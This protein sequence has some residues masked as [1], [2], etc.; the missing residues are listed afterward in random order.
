MY[1]QSGQAEVKAE[2]NS[3]RIGEQ[4]NLELNFNYTT[5]DSSKIVWPE[6]DNYLTNSIEIIN[7]SSIDSS[8]IVCD[9]TVCPKFK[10]QNLIITSFEPGNLT[11]PAIKFKIDDKNYYSDPIP[12]L[13]NTVAVDTAKGMYDVY[14]IYEVEYTFAEKATDFSKQY[15]HWFLIVGLLIVIFILYKKYKNRPVEYIAPPEIIIPAHIKALQTLNQLKFDK[16]W[17]DENRKKY[18]SDLT[19][20]VRQYLEDRF[21]IQALEQTTSEIIQDLKQADI[22]ADDKAFL[23]QILQQADFV[24]FA[25]FEPRNEGGL[26]ALDKSFEFVHRTKLEIMESDNVE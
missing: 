17:E 5:H 15:W 14:P 8:N 19:D 23:Q 20:T 24:K 16:A 1:G 25:K 21:E 12:L 6:F 3:I 13:V 18:Y 22:S 11:I 4:I 7:K 10:K 2:R 26:N 9:S